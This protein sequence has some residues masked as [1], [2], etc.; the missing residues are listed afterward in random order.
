MRLQ[1]VVEDA[2]ADLFVAPKNLRSALVDWINAELMRYDISSS[3]LQCLHDMAT[4]NL[5]V[6]IIDIWRSDKR[7][8]VLAPAREAINWQFRNIVCQTWWSLFFCHREFNAPSHMYQRYFYHLPFSDVNLQPT[9]FLCSYR[10]SARLKNRI[11]DSFW[12][13]FNP[14]APPSNKCNVDWQNGNKL[15]AYL[16][17]AIHPAV[18]D[19]NSSNIGGGSAKN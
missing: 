14:F 1:Y 7:D 3:A 15:G 6:Q 10:V 5:P 16:C 19:H 2:A 13:L 8:I 11:R 4:D 12:I 18:V 17:N 9:L